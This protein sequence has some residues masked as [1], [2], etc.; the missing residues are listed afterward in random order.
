MIIMKTNQSTYSKT[1]TT[2]GNKSAFVTGRSLNSNILSQ[3]II[4][5]KAN[6]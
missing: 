1:I 6:D 2:E 4:L 5:Q 3:E